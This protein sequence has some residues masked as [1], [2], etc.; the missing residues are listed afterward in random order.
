M[1]RTVNGTG[2]R[3]RPDDVASFGLVFSLSSGLLL[4]DLGR[5]LLGFSVLMHPPRAVGP[6]F[7]GVV[8]VV[9]CVMQKKAKEKPHPR[10]DLNP[11]PSPCSF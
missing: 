2:Q 9:A 8:V 6:R 1:P 5:V 7:D 10:W 11:R 4:P 3:G